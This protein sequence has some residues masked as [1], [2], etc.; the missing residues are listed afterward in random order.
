MYPLK[1]APV[2]QERL[3]GGTNLKKIFGRD[4]T[5]DHIGESWDVSGHS[6][7]MSIVENGYL[8]GKSLNQLMIEYREKLMGKKFAE[9]QS[10]PILVK[11]L[12]ANDN[13]SIQVHPDDEYARRV[14]GE[15]GKTEAWYVIY[16]K[17]DAHIIYGLKDDITKETFM[18]AVEMHHIS[19]VIKK[20][21]V[22]AGDMIYVPSGTVHALLEGVMV[23][24]IQQNS[25]T[26]YRIYDYDRV[27]KDG[28]LRELHIDKAL[29]VITF[30]KQPS[31]VFTDHSISCQY[32]SVEKLS[33]TGEL[34][35]E[36]KER[37]IIYCVI[38]GAGE[39]VYQDKRESLKPG[40]TVLIP[41]CLKNFTLQG[42]LRLLQIT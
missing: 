4:I 34:H 35:E 11:I 28:K 10:F 14:E 30:T 12:D 32:F 9:N 27:T 36:T 1:F 31:C 25:D 38:E 18:K 7:G 26:T 22:K 3:W 21:P 23:Y 5:S 39:V 15:A 41:A 2:Y 33:V 13:L 37:F 24:E 16:A 19:D 17:D 42:N 40:D 29:D 8:A 20:V 6:N